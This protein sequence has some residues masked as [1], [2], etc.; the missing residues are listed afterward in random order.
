MIQTDLTLAAVRT[1]GGNTAIVAN[2]PDG[3]E[4]F[5]ANNA[6]MGTKRAM[7]DFRAGR[8]TMMAEAL[9]RIREVERIAREAQARID[10]EGYDDL[11]AAADELGINL[12]AHLA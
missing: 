9:K 12:D 6:A 10:A 2:L 11:V 8:G 4:L 1:N 7:L 5:I 3:R